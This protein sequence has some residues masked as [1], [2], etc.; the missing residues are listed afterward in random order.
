MRAFRAPRPRTKRSPSPAWRRREEPEERAGAGHDAGEGAGL[1]RPD[2][3][4]RLEQAAFG[5]IGRGAAT[6]DPS[7]VDGPLPTSREGSSP[8]PRRCPAST[9]PSRSRLGC[10]TAPGTGEKAAAVFVIPNWNLSEL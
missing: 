3:Q 6:L 7:K 4:G 9:A 8:V 1:T 5:W 2:P 10:V